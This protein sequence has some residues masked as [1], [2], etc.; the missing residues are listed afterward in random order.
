[1]ASRIRL[2]G[3][4]GIVTGLAITVLAMAGRPAHSEP[5]DTLQT[6]VTPME[7]PVEVEIELSP[8]G[9]LKQ[10][11]L[12]KEL[13]QMLENP[14]QPVERRPGFGVEMPALNVWPLDYNFLTGQ[15]L[16]RRTSD[17]EISWDLPGPL[18]DPDETVATDEFNA[19]TELRSVI[20]AL[21]AC[22]LPTPSLQDI[23]DAIAQCQQNPFQCAEIFA[24]LQHPY[25]LANPCIGAP[26]GSLVVTNP[27]NF[28]LRNQLGFAGFTADPRIPPDRTVVAES[29]I[30]GLGQLLDEDGEPVTELE[31]PINEE[32]FFREEEDVAGV[33][34]PLQEYVGRYAAEVLGKSFFW[35]M[36]VGSDGVQACGSCHF[37]AGVDNRTRGQLNP[38]V[39]GGDLTLQV[40]GPNENVVPSDFPFHKRIDPDVVGDGMDPAIVLSDA[41]D[42]MSSMGVS[43]FKLFNDI[44]LGSF[45]PAYNGVT[46]LLPDDGTPMPDPVPV[47]QGLRRVEPR[48]TPTFHGA[49]FNFDNFWDGRARFNFNGG[50]VFGPSDPQFHIFIEDELGELVGAT[51]GHIDDELEEEDPE[52]AEQPVRIKFSSLGSQA[53]GPPLSEFE[54]SFLG[55]NWPKIGKKLLQ[56]GVTP[57][58]NQLVAT[59]DSRLGPFSNQGGSVC[60]AL[61]RATAVDKPGLCVSYPELIELAFASD[62][63]DVDDMHLAGAECDDPFDAY[64]LSIAAGAADSADTNQFTQMEANLSLFFGLSVQ[65]YESLTIPDDSPA[66]R[67]F[68]MNPNAGHGVG[69]PG[70][71]AVLFPTLV[72][73]LMDDGELNNSVPIPT[74]G[75]LVLIPDDPSTPEYDGFGPD[76][77]FG[78]DIFA[79]ANLTAALPAGSPRNPIHT[80]TTESGEEVE[81]AVGS[82]P[83]TRSA[84]CML[85]HL[86]AEQTDHSINVAHGLLKNDAE[87][88]YPTP[89]QV[90]DNNPV[91]IFL[92]GLLPAP[93]P[94]GGFRAVGGLILA[95]E[96]TEGA[97]QDAVEVE[98]RNFATFDDPA[99]PW[100]D[101][102]IA[103]P[104]NFAFGDQGVYNIG[105]RP[106]AEDIGRGGDDPFGWPLSLSALTL[107]NIG[108]P[109]YEP[110]DSSTDVCV[111]ANF[112]PFD[113]EATFEETGDGEVFPGT[114]HTVQSINPGFERSPINPLMPEYMVPWLHGL[115]AGELHPQIDEL[116]GMVPNTLTPPNGGPA[117]EFPEV[118][119][120]ADQHCGLYDPAQF[121]SGPPNFGWGPSI[122]DPDDSACPTNQSGV[123]GNMDWPVHGT[124]PVPNRVIRDG[125]FKA[126]PLRNVALTGP[127]F[128]TGSYLTLRQVVDFYVRGGDFPITNAENR[129]PNIND[130]MNQSFSFGRTNSIDGD[131]DSL[132][133]FGFLQGYFADALPDPV[134]R[135]DAM[136]DTDHPI[137]PEYATPE[138]AKVALVKFMISLT[139]PR[140]AYERAP[141]DRPEI[142]VPIDGEAP[143]NTGGRQQLLDMSGVPCGEGSAGICFRH[144][145]AV[146]A[147]GN[148]TPVSGFLGVTNNPNADCISEIS[149]FCR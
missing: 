112:D 39:N 97:A 21:V 3:L 68:D 65:A 143:E 46:A 23:L 90:A 63:W 125:T 18:F 62:F 9:S 56:A 66:D 36:Q 5:G 73:D 8:A 142:F 70:D 110:C 76:E 12:W 72:P 78:F 54:M 31:A 94:S 43:E 19:P 107:K 141:F 16:R 122:G 111:M 34:V 71:Q 131:F 83:F 136:P 77:V 37:H 133:D 79:G 60:T 50:S 22:P 67:F 130:L 28:F 51:N 2:V 74:T 147:G 24:Q 120:G 40:R 105:L 149:H 59:D 118:L 138:D 126:P 95:E 121:G 113:L 45:S 41:N 1:M 38:G 86:G 25:S 75:E 103:Q 84:K 135:Y 30:N 48:N 93:E 35:D 100:D 96:T 27:N 123:A 124:W 144:I 117:I 61:G 137:T 134:Y 47:N 55:R 87:F 64:C 82:N 69:E 52:A 44:V 85:C 102:V 106:S 129:D 92:D 88:E 6:P 13:Y 29:A 42:V 80:I 58:A 33:P 32:D 91:N 119:F 53:V 146:G 10:A 49:A 127:Y 139:D 99:T 20:G 89:P 104:S 11:P 108:G 109:M 17:G 140:V 128:H 114:S 57:L 15:P 81:I 148:A 101:R 98:P 4:S 7:L 115:P 145:P 132:I 26:Q 116:A 14:Y